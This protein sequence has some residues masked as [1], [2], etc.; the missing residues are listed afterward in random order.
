[1]GKP[2]ART[3]TTQCEALNAL[4][5]FIDDSWFDDAASVLQSIS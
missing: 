1:M 5:A 2:Y 3:E 4:I